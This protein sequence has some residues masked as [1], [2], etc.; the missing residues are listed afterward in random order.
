M[1]DDASSIGNRFCQKRIDTEHSR[2]SETELIEKGQI[3]FQKLRCMSG[4]PIDGPAV[5]PYLN[6]IFTLL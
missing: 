4:L 1:A 2:S 3:V 5:R 6:T